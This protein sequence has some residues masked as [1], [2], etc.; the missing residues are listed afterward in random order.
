ML[1]KSKCLIFEPTRK[2]GSFLNQKP[3]FYIEGNVIEIFNQWTY[4]GHIID[5]RSD[6]GAD[7]L[8]RR[9]SMVGQIHDVFC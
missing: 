9:N 4:H 5:N 2:A 1:T 8:F 7:M 6:D 3:V